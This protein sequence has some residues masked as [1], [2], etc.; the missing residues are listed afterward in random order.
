MSLTLL[1]AL[2]TCA[3]CPLVPPDMR[4]VAGV[5]LAVLWA[6][7]VQA[8]V[9]LDGDLTGDERETEE[10]SKLLMHVRRN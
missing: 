6:G 7:D 3:P 10:K 2:G 8:A 5:H 4:T 9:P 1:S